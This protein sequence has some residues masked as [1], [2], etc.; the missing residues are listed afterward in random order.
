M[1][2]RCPRCFKMVFCQ[3]TDTD[4]V[5]NCNSGKDSIDNEDVVKIG[6]ATEFGET[7]SVDSNMVPLQGIDNKI[8]GTEASF[9]Q[10]KQ[11][12]R[13]A[14]GAISSTH[15]QRK[16]HEFIELKR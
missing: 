7:V 11:H 9:E 4:I 16:H 12:D 3:S 5:H 2:V 1:Q 15:R 8:F 6:T 10:R 13:T 14:R